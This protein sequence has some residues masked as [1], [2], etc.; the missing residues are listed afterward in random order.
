MPESPL[1]GGF[2]TPVVRV[3]D[4]VRRRPA[5]RTDFVHRLLA[6]F[7]QAGWAGAPRFLGMDDRRRETLSFVAGH[8][9]WE[10]HQS[11]AVGCDESLARAATLVR[12]FHDLTAGTDLAGDQEVVCHNDLAPKNTVYRDL[13]TGLRPVAFIDW[14]LAAPGR[15]IHDIAHVCWQYLPRRRRRPRDR[16]P[17]PADLRRLRT[18]RHE[19]GDRR[20]PVVAGPV[21]ARHPGRRRGRRPGDDPPARERRRTRDRGRPPLGRS[22][23]RRPGVLMT[24]PGPGRW[25]G[26]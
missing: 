4:T 26:V 6:L 12:E 25:R 3:G 13:G 22:A 23:P 1:P 2:V 5:P 20:D 19:R 24:V 10:P 7:E 9:A 15:R 14:D 17:G 18:G 11:P 8:V 16:P 21:R